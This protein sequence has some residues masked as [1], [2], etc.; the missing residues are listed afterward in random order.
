MD[1]AKDHQL[2][3]TSSGG[4][5]KVE[6]VQ[7]FENGR[8]Q[9]E[10]KKQSRLKVATVCILCFFNLTYY[11][12]RFG[13]AGILPSIQCDLGASD[14]QGGLLQTAFIVP[15]VI[16]SPVVG[17]LGDRNSRK[18]ILVLGIFFWSCATLTASFMPNLW[19]FIVLRSLTGVGEACF[20][21]L[22]PAIISDLYASNVRSKFLAI[23]YFA[24]PVGSGLGYIVFAEV[25]NATN[26]WRWGLRVTP[27]F[28]FICVVLILLFLQDPPRGESEGSRMKTTSWMDDIKY[29]ATHGSYIWISVA[30]TAVA[31]IAG[32]FGAWGPKYITLGLVTQQE[33][34]TEDIGD[35]L[36]RV[37]LIFGFITVVTGLMGVV[38]GSL[39]GTKLRG[40]YP[41]IDP[42]ICGFGVL[43]SVPLIFAMTVL[44]RGPEAPTYI[45]FFFGQW[46]LNL[47]WAL[48]TDMLMYTIVPTRRSSAKA[49]QILLNH[50]LGDAGSPYIIGLLS[51]AFKPLVDSGHNSTKTHHA[52]TISSSLWD[53]PVAREQDCDLSPIDVTT[54]ERDFTALQYALF[55]SLFIQV[56]GAFAF[57]AT[58]WTIIDD[59]A[60]VDRVAALSQR[61]DR[62]SKQLDSIVDSSSEKSP[63]S[64]STITTSEH[65]GPISTNVS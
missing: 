36:G 46:F 33:G 48:A 25:G 29:F 57:I 1:A 20:S 27:I 19:S 2:E 4:S 11:M 35:L 44:A 30:S 61:K 12:D 8:I 21:S 18:L 52:T 49:I 26:D 59:K 47:N 60:E 42:E 28:G 15:Y 31:F 16:F 24:I 54:A 6:N 40:K 64:I 56:L 22:A 3:E 14:K 43:A 5:E 10:S 45:T 38:V 34:Q 32:A 55:I 41:T 63:V 50:V 58:S 51:D 53:S 13:I 7:G 37:S 17:Y 39:M 62:N 23:Y 65:T 9:V